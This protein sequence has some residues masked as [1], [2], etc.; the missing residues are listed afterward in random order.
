MVR[1]DDILVTG[2]SD[3]DHMQNLRMVLQRL[4]EA[5]LR[6]KTEKCAFMEDSVIYNGHRGNE[7][8]ISPTEDKLDAVLKAPTPKNAT[9]LRSYLG[10]I[11]YYGTLLHNLS[12]VVALLNM[13]LKKGC[14]WKWGE[15]TEQ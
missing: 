11:N 15:G 6:A 12:S 10:L 4:A 2:T 9:E 3:E 7:T 1:V 5:G 13:L 8:G 14:H